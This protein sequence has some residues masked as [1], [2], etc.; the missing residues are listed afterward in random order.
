MIKRVSRAEAEVFPLPGRDWHTY[1]GP[2]NTPTDRVTDWLSKPNLRGQAKGY[3]TEIAPGRTGTFSHPLLDGDPQIRADMCDVLGLAGDP[4][5][6]AV[7]EPL[8]QDREPQVSRAAER[9]IA[10]LK[11]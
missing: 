10:R 3:L 4:A 11:R 8:V 1:I 7:L 5:A 2:Q 9:A 6:I